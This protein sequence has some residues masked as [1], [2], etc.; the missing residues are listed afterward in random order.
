MEIKTKRGVWYVVNPPAPKKQFESEE[1]AIAYVR[2]QQFVEPDD[3]DE[4]E[5]YEE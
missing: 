5:W 4:D 1:A 3:D 2:G